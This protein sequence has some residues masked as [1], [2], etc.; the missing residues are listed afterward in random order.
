MAPASR[1]TPFCT[2][3]LAG[4][5]Q[6]IEHDRLRVWVLSSDSCAA[7]FI[8]LPRTLIGRVDRHNVYVA[9]R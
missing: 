6:S 9:D 2:W 4:W 3:L 8:N 7:T 5:V 1:G